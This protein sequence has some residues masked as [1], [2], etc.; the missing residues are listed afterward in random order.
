[1]CD[2]NVWEPTLSVKDTEVSQTDE[3]FALTEPMV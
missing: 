3:F 1:M 2:Y